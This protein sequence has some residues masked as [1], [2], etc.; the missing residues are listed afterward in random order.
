MKQIS[1][2]KGTNWHWSK[3]IFDVTHASWYI[4]KC[5]FSYGWKSLHKQNGNV[6]PSIL[7]LIFHLN[8]LEF[9]KYQIVVC[10][11]CSFWFVY[12]IIFLTVNLIFIF[13]LGIVLF[14][15]YCVFLHSLIIFFSLI[16]LWIYQLL[17]L[18][19]CWSK[20]T[21]TKTDS[22]SQRFYLIPQW[23]SYG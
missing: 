23:C 22:C 7:L 5:K 9:G 15:W 16:V 6:N 10:L 13:C 3:R 20:V 19:C 11:R 18:L 2:C 21:S 4:C 8:K 12:Q 17:G 14:R 1:I